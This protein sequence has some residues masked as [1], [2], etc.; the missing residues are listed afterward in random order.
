MGFVRQQRTRTAAKHSR[1]IINVVPTVQSFNSSYMLFRLMSMGMGVG[2]IGE[3]GGGQ[4]D[5]RTTRCGLMGVQEGCESD[6]C[7]NGRGQWAGICVFT[8]NN[9]YDTSSNEKCDKI[10]VVVMVVVENNKMNSETSSEKR[11]QFA[12]QKQIRHTHTVHIQIQTRMRTAG[13]D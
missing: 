8:C 11:I 2:V 3:I 13:A 12:C 5:S 4:W 7:E 9:V 1:K 6:G 10:V